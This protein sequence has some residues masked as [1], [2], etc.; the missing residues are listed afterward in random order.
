M[1]QGINGFARRG[2]L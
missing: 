2:R 1:K